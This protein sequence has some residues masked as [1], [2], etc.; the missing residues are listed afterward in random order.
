MNTTVNNLKQGRRK[1]INTSGVPLTDSDHLCYN[2]ILVKSEGNCWIGYSGD[3]PFSEQSYYFPMKSG[4]ELNI[5]TKH[6]SDIYV[7]APGSGV[8]VYWILQ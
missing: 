6:T 4:D 1:N 2:G 5:Y 8:T 3:S 7:Q